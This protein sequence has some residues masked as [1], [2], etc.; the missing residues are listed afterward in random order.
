[1]VAKRKECI[2]FGRI[3]SKLRAARGYSQE[4]FAAAAGVHRTYMGGIERG[5]RNPTL[6]TI[7]RLA[8]ALELEPA[9]LFSQ[10]PGKT[11]P[12]RKD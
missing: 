11:P 5:E 6:T 8:E 9:E 1:M 4:G 3:I 12:R 2:Q 10:W 7:L